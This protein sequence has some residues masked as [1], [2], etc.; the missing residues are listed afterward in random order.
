MGRRAICAG[1]TVVI[2]IGSGFGQ[3]AAARPAFVVASIKSYAAGAPFPAGGG[4]GSKVS[5]DGVA[6]RYTRLLFCI[7]WAYDTPGRVV[8]PEWIKDRYDI[9]AKASGP[10]P[11][12]QLKLMTQS[13]LTD[14]FKLKVH[15]EK[16]ELPVVVMSVAKGGPRNLQ[17]AES[18]DPPIYETVGGK[19]VF[20]GTMSGL[21]AILGNSPPFGVR[22]QVVDRT[23]ITGPFN[24][25]LNVGDFDVDDPVFGGR[26]EEMQSA[27]FS[28][29]TAALE[30]Q[31]GLR[32]EHRKV[33]LESIVVDSGNK[34]PTEN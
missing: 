2:T 15:R 4:N 26:F 11:E 3:S 14:R 22:E 29:L 13:L 8:G 7:A 27:A 21:A 18:G 33:S 23:G 6:W 5:P 24:L 34:V 28:F 12:A 20:R 30:K 17:R 16:R 25:T 31:L 1:L 32:L 10:V 9:T 19:L